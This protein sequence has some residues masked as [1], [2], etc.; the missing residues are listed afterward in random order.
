MIGHGLRKPNLD[1]LRKDN[2]RGFSAVVK[3]AGSREGVPRP[4]LS[5]LSCWSR[6]WN[7][8]TCYQRFSNVW[9]SCH[10]S[11]KTPIELVIINA[12]IFCWIIILPLLDVKTVPII[13]NKKGIFCTV[14]LPEI[15]SAKTNH[16]HID[17]L[18]TINANMFIIQNM[19][20]KQICF[21]DAVSNSKHSRT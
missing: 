12:K 11:C 2:L 4:V 3:G 7:Q 13:K 5:S 21:N 16:W 18:T 6:P 1:W 20:L 9:L 8:H 19:S 10:A 15:R 14:I 17:N